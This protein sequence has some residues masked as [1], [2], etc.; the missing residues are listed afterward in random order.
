MASSKYPERFLITLESGT[1]ARI[2]EVLE[3]FEGRSH[4]LR[5]AVEREIKRRKRRG[6]IDDR[7]R[8][9]HRASRLR[10]TG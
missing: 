2:D 8:D 6:V 5:E 9:Q 7:E 4:M 3:R 1:F 10:A